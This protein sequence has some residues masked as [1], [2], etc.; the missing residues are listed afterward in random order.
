MVS[1]SKCPQKRPLERMFD[2]IPEKSPFVP[3]DHVCPA[4]AMFPHGDLYGETLQVPNPLPGGF[5]RTP[6]SGDEGKELARSTNSGGMGN[7]P[8]S[9]LNN[10]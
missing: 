5:L 7:H 9:A 4:Q 1:T 6:G 3:G 10:H 8:R 2:M